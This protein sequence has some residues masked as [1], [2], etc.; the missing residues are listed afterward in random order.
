MELGTFMIR[1]LVLKFNI[2]FTSYD[3]SFNAKFSILSDLIES[4][5]L[6][7]REINQNY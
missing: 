5:L 7:G 3:R 2:K 4:K 1:L 6:N